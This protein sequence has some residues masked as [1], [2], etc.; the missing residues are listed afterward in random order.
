MK[1]FGFERITMVPSQLTSTSL[2]RHLR[3][4]HLRATDKPALSA[5]T[6]A[7][8]PLPLHL[9]PHPFPPARPVDTRLVSYNLLSRSEKAWLKA[10][11]E[12]VKRAIL[13]LVKEDRR[14]RD[15]LKRQ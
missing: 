2:V 6:N 9:L 3:C 5:L 1:W 10:H 11:N 4:S 8:H 13:P 15:W 14:A 7:P 12:T